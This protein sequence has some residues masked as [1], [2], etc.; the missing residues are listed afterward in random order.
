MLKIKSF[1]SISNSIIASLLASLLLLLLS[2]Y[3]T[4]SSSSPLFSLLPLPAKID[5]F[6]A[7]SR[8]IDSFLVI[9][10]QLV[11]WLKRV[12]MNDLQ[13]DV[14]DRLI[15]LFG[16]VG[17]EIGEGMDWP[18]GRNNCVW[19]DHH[20]LKNVLLVDSVNEIVFGFNVSVDLFSH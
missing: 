1:F 19:P 16:D 6:A 15:V 8:S 17:I 18:I 14:S 13:V 10:L 9:L 2:L 3:L 5:A 12:Q 4:I 7:V 20:E 11:I